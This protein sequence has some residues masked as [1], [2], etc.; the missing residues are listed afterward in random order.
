MS[1]NSD[2]SD[3]RTQRRRDPTGIKTEAWKHTL[4]DMDAIAAERRDDGWDVRTLFSVH[5]DTVSRD[6][7]DHDD[8]GLFHIV[9]NNQ[10]HSFEEWFDPEE[11]T[12]YLVYGTDVEG[13]MYAVIE[14]IDPEAERSILLASRYDMTR[15]KGMVQ[16]AQDEGVLYS[17]VKTVDGTV[18]GVFEHEEFNPLVAKPGE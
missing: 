9:P 13:Y 10:I 5:T 16:S 11:F 12:E 17:R 15:A 2:P 1:E 3:M 8:F 4:D 6:M 18:L 7:G 14:F